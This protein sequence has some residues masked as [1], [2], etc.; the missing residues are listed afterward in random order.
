[1]TIP[2]EALDLESRHIGRDAEPT[3]APAY[4]ILKKHWQGGNRDRDL[5]LHLMFLAWYGQ[6][7]PGSL[8]GFTDAKEEKA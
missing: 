7:E 1:M 6:I 4:E 8:T 2:Q 5:G 3:L